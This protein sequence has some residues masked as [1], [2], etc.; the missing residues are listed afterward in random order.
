M[1]F[2]GVIGDILRI[3][4][5]A[6]A[7]VFEGR[8]FTYAEL[9]R[10][11]ELLDRDLAG[12]GVGPGTLVAAVLPN[13]PGGV[14]AILAVLFR[15]ACLVPLS[16]RRADAD[17]ATIGAVGAVIRPGSTD[18]ADLT[19]RVEHGDAD[20]PTRDGVAS[21]VG[22]AGTTGPPKRVPVTY[23]SIDASLTGTRSKA[24]NKGRTG[25][26][27]DV[28]IVCF[29]LAHL[30]GLVP[31][32]ITILTGRRVA[33][34]AKFEPSEAAAIVKAHGITSLALNPT[35][36]A[37][38]LD[39]DLDPTD[40][41]TLRFV[42]SG[43]APLS[44]EL[45]GAFSDRFGVMVMQA[46][47]Q[48]ETGGEVIGWSPQ[49]WNDFGVAKRGSVGRP[50]PGLAVRIV[51]PGAD[52]EAGG[53]PVGASGELW[54]RGV[55]GHESW[56]RTGD[57]ARV[58]EDGFVWVLGRA[59]DT[60]I[61]GGFNIAPLAIEHVLERHPAIQEAAVVGAPDRR[62]G[63]IPVAVIVERDGTAVSDDELDAW[64][65]EHLEPYQAPRAYVR[66][67]ALPRNDAGKV[68]RP[69]TRDHALAA[70]SE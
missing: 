64:S 37:M 11:V 36:V 58:D 1:D 39:S 49:E 38:L 12:A 7:L 54:L 26:R 23:E 29:P 47:G 35:A 22:T 28:T 8:W 68:H 43:S 70:M 40:L 2:V 57:I 25:L 24:G 17:L 27:D 60:I 9:S 52:P 59:D 56:H 55:R 44:P 62:L 65:R 21:L 48:T 67:S 30:S 6:R 53:L 34:M 19:W 66:V 46:Y 20:A 41:A 33:L 16:P 5:I 61:C 14:V 15:R 42:R 13:T 45:A 32:L 63:Q 18:P 10:A 4:P 50:H 3:D 31:L 51:D 69:T